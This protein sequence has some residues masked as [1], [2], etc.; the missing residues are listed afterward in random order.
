MNISPGIRTR[1]FAVVGIICTLMASAIPQRAAKAAGDDIRVA[2]LDPRDQI[3]PDRPGD[4]P[5]PLG[6]D[7][8]A[9]YRLVFQLQE[10]GRWS[11]ADAQVE[12]LSNQLLMG[13]VLAQRYLHPDY[14]TSYPELAEWLDRYADLPEA[15]RLY[16]L[17]RQRA[18]KDAKRLT[19]PSVRRARATGHSPAARLAKAPAALFEAGLRQWQQD[20]LDGAA[21]TFAALANSAKAD[22]SEVAAGAFWAARAHLKAGR[23]QM[24]A[25]YLRVAAKTG[26]PFYGRLAQTMLGQPLTFEWEEI[27]LRGDMIELLI[28]Y[29]GSRRAVALSQIG[30]LD[31]AEEEVRLLSDR[32]EVELSY[33]LAALA[34]AAGLPAA[35]MQ[36]AEDL[37]RKDG[38]RYESS[39]YPM[40][41]WKPD[42]GF[43]LD[44]A[45]I[46]GIV[47]A[48]SGF[49]KNARSNRGAMGLM[50][51][52]PTTAAQVARKTGID[53]R[54]ANAL[55]NPRTNLAIGQAWVRRLAQMSAIDNNLVHILVAYNA[56][57]NRVATWLDGKM[58]A[59]ADD[60]LLFIE[61]IP[62]TETRG[63]VKK[64]LSNIWVYR[65]RLGQQNIELMEMAENKWPMMTSIDPAAARV[66]R[67]N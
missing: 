24:V 22:P 10:L 14:T 62:I 9:R 54:D 27:A 1:A 66:A 58:A 11:E 15:D 65:L 18:P 23:P 50:Q 49:D 37:Y 33:A 64:V 47:R 55:K 26:D 34:E 60:P 16:V 20:R 6:Y 31:L 57:Q 38:R 46:Y 56:G 43:R 32:S 4:L 44:R 8:I 28:R 53:Y 61:R 39:L 5:R 17:A 42:G 13:H 35:Q 12:R 51:V 45:L 21:E 7:D 41:D 48:E 36:V 40:P 3:P 30:Q 52:M 19:A 29:P 67:A 2:R 25:R 63:Y 59:Y